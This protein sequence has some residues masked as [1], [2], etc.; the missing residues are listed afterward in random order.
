MCNDGLI[1]SIT[2]LIITFPRHNFVSAIKLPLRNDGHLQ[3]FF[4][5][6]LQRI[7]NLLNIKGFN[8]WHE[9]SLTISKITHVKHA[10]EYPANLKC[11]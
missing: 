6:A 1:S 2:A 8:S 10:Y 5:A 4:G 11:R 7:C 3:C 9:N